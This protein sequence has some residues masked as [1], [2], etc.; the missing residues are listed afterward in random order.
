MNNVRTQE[1][2]MTEQTGS[3]GRNVSQTIKT[4]PA[5]F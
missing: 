2:K 4:S 1:I 3:E 5:P